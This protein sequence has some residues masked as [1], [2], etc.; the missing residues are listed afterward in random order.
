MDVDRRK[1]KRLE[2][3]YQTILQ[4]HLR[5]C[6]RLGIRI[7]GRYRYNTPASL[8]VKHRAIRLGDVNEPLTREQS[9][10]RINILLIIVCFILSII[11]MAYIISIVIRKPSEPIVVM[12]KV[13]RKKVATSP[14]MEM[15]GIVNHGNLFAFGNENNT[16]NLPTLPRSGTIGAKIFPIFENNELWFVYSDP[17]KPII[18]FNLITKKHGTLPKNSHIFTDTHLVNS[19]GVRVGGYFWAI[20]GTDLSFTSL[21]SSMFYF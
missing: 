13:H 19:M 8:K 1:A 7:K 16:L 14:P 11:L 5:E 17:K 6:K 3:R 9:E 20:G 10:D 15:I 18:T 21:F 12:P 2:K 4:L